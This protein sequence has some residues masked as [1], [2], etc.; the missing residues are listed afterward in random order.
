MGHDDGT[1]MKKISRVKFASI[2]QDMFLVMYHQI[3]FI[4]HMVLR[5]FNKFI[6]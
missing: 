5:S 2:I 3:N 4:L 1:I 6:S